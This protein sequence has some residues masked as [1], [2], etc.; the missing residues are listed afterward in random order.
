MDDSP[1]QLEK[2]NLPIAI[3]ELGMA[4]LLQPAN[5]VLEDFSIIALQLPR[6]SY[7]LLSESTIRFV[8]PEQPLKTP[9][10]I[11]VTD[12]GIVIEISS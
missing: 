3:I 8:S 5:R 10:P 4:V 7:V 6:E 11:A 2:A 1:E 9:V 12:L